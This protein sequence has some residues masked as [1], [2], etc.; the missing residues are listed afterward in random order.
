VSW[1]GR[2][3]RLAGREGGGGDQDVH[4]PG[5]LPLLLEQRGDPS[6]QPRGLGPTLQDGRFYR[7]ASTLRSSRAGS[8]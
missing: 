4:V 8:S 6:E 1:V 3:E 5:G 7:R 2:D